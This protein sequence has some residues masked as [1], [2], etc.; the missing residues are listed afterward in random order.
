MS[1]D[2]VGSKDCSAAVFSMPKLQTVEF[3]NVK[4]EYPF[5]T[6]MADVAKSSLVRKLLFV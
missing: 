6:S 1:L 5:Y 4:L 2:Q 3:N